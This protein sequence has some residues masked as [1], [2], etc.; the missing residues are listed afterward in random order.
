MFRA[1][2]F[3]LPALAAV[4]LV[5]APSQAQ[6][7]S[8]V[9]N[10]PDN[11]LLQGFVW[12][13]IGPVGQGG[14]VDD[15]AVHP[16]DTR[17]WYVGFATG[18]L[19]KTVNDGTTFRHDEH[20]LLFTSTSPSTLH[21]A[22]RCAFFS[23]SGAKLACFCL[24]TTHPFGPL[25]SSPSLLHPLHLSAFSPSPPNIGVF[26]PHVEH[27]LFLT[28][29]SPSLRHLPHRSAFMPRFWANKA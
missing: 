5:A 26:S 28:S 24:H 11:P 16:T 8:P 27:F 20:F 23:P 10:A 29:L 4:L 9:I 25:I 19:W 6:E 12:R 2:R 13:S 22:H 21:P 7:D 1:S 17:I 18:G 15:I 3:V 14:R